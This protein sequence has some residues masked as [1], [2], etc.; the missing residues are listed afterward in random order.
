MRHIATHPR[1]RNVTG[2]RAAT[3]LGSDTCLECDCDVFDHREMRVGS[4][5]AYHCHFCGCGEC[6][7]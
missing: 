2:V 7:W 6:S 5:I 4:G 3:W 1:A